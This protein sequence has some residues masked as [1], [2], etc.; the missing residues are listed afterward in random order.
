MLRILEKTAPDVMKQIGQI[1]ESN[2]SLKQQLKMIEKHFTAR[3]GVSITYKNR[4]KCS[5]GLKLMN[6]GQE[7]HYDNIKQILISLLPKTIPYLEEQQQVGTVY[8]KQDVMKL[9]EELPDEFYQ[10]NGKEI[11]ISDIFESVFLIQ[12]QYAVFLEVIMREMLAERCMEQLE[13]MIDDVISSRISQL[14]KQAT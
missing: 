9:L 3:S 10:L 7:I 6:M 12:N 14:R 2:Q 8:S 4:V 13:H 5:V 11:H 1:V